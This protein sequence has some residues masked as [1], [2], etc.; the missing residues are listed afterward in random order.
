MI[1]R[2]LWSSL[3]AYAAFF[4]V[5]LGV[6]LVAAIFAFTSN[7]TLNL[8]LGALTAVGLLL[9]LA[10]PLLSL[11]W[12]V[13]RFGKSTRE[14]EK[15]PDPPTEQPRTE[16]RRNPTYI[17]YCKQGEG[18]KVDSFHL[19]PNTNE[20]HRDAGNTEN[21]VGG[22]NLAPDNLALAIRKSVSIPVVFEPL[23]GCYD[24]GLL[25]NLPVHE[26]RDEFFK[27]AGTKGTHT[28]VVTLTD[29]S[30]PS[31]KKS[32]Y[33]GPFKAVETIQTMVSL[34]LHQKEWTWVNVTAKPE[35]SLTVSIPITTIA[36]LDFHLTPDEKKLLI[37]EGR[38]AATRAL[39]KGPEQK[40]PESEGEKASTAKSL[41]CG[42]KKIPALLVLKGGGAKGLALLGAVDELAKRYEFV[43]FAGTS[44]GA[45]TAGL[46]G[47]GWSP[48]ALIDLF[49]RENLGKLLGSKTS[50]LSNLLCSGF[51]FDGDHFQK[52]VQRHLASGPVETEQATSDAT[53][54]TDAD[55]ETMRKGVQKARC[56]PTFRNSA[57]AISV[58]LIV[59]FIV[60]S[61]LFMY[62]G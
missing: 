25:A 47:A 15:A 6:L 51:L 40:A 3:A 42:D 56:W 45:I 43:G 27:L 53:A 21:H 28:V 9:L 19:P 50:V 46:L 41:D 24:G 32:S 58:I 20:A 16:P 38:L 13:Q 1:S 57:L 34:W 49:D 60:V 33:C 18:L 12:A 5:P 44:A 29:G 31:G 11:T 7:K 17:F 2:L 59:T 36:T 35:D 37:A 48:A 52:W 39:Q 26:A 30:A 4:S 23:H 61:V 54:L 10:V 14:G 22:T 55:V 62:S 8:L